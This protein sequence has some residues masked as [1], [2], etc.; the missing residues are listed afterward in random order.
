MQLSGM[1]I[2]LEAVATTG[3]VPDADLS[4]LYQRLH[5]LH[6]LQTLEMSIHKVKLMS[7]S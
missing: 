6:I 2:C 4:R 1:E 7:Y 3:S 5:T